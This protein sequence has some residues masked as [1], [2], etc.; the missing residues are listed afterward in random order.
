MTQKTIK[1]P[2]LARVEGEGALELEIRN[3]NG[4]LIF[5]IP[6]NEVNEKLGAPSVAIHRAALQKALLQYFDKKSLQ[7]KSKIVDFQ[8]DEH[9]VNIQLENHDTIQADL[10]IGADGFQSAVRK[11]LVADSRTTLAASRYAS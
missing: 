8:E 9:Q 7:L 10:L 3:N 1:V 4:S 11:K 5:S 2:I 6:V